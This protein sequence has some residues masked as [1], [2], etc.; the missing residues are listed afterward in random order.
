LEGEAWGDVDC[1]GLIYL[2]PSDTLLITVLKYLLC[3]EKGG[4]FR[5]NEIQNLKKKKT[6]IYF[7]GIVLLRGESTRP[8]RNK[9][10]TTTRNAITFHTITIQPE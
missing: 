5:K 8:T 6:T 2:C 4:K 7:A 10:K 1:E 3:F 9:S